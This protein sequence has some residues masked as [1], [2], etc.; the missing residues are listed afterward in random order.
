MRPFAFTV[1]LLGA[2][3]VDLSA[4]GAAPAAADQAPAASPPPA[5]G[6]NGEKLYQILYAGEF[7]ATSQAVGQRARMLAWMDSVGFTADQ[8]GGLAQLARAVRGQEARENASLATLDQS[9]N[10]TIT[11]VYQDLVNVYANGGTATDAQLAPFAARLEAARTE[12]YGATDPH[13]A[14]YAAVNRALATVSKWVSALPQAQKDRLGEARF[15]LQRKLG[16]FTNPGDYEKWLGTAWNGAD[17]ASL[18]AQG[19]PVDE[20]QMDIGGLWTDD[21][22]ADQALPGLRVAV[23]LLFAIEQDGFLEAIEVRLGTRAPNDYS[24]AAS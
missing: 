12:A 14:H 8:L 2:C 5:P 10:V 21:A 4:V 20:G 19:R 3:Q 15:F 13:T 7:G 9:E 24:P 22:S 6:P 11:P 17:F 18:R 1:L 16:P 23:V